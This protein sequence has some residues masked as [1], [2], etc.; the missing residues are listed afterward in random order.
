MP[1]F[2]MH[3]TQRQRRPPQLSEQAGDDSLPGAAGRDDGVGLRE[4]ASEE[5]SGLD[6]APVSHELPPNVQVWGT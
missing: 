3:E 4:S 6:T 5:T 2:S 1:S